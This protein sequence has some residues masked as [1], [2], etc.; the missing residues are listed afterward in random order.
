MPKKTRLY[1]E[2]TQREREQVRVWGGVGVYPPRGLQSGRHEQRAACCTAAD[3]Q[4]LLV[5][6][7]WQ[8]GS[9]PALFCRHQHLNHSVHHGLYSS[10]HFCSLRN[11]AHLHNHRQRCVLSHRHWF[12]IHAVHPCL[13]PTAATSATTTPCRLRTCTALSSGTWPN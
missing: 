11:R 3:N 9:S 2:Q 4:S 10:S 5:H 8:P 6:G 7:G 13:A 12:T 1:V